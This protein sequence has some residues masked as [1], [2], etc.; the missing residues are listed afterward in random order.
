M[1]RRTARLLNFDDSEIEGSSYDEYSESGVSESSAD[2]S[3]TDT[4]VMDIPYG[5]TTMRADTLVQQIPGQ[6]KASISASVRWKCT[7]FALLDF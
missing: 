2:E 4:S 6:D 7:E 3:E 5:R 1:E